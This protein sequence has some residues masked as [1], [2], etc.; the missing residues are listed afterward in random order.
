[1]RSDGGTGSERMVGRICGFT[2]THRYAFA[3]E[4]MVRSDGA[5][6]VQWLIRGWVRPAEIMDS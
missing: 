4:C 1:M 2:Y 6:C 3:G 5:I